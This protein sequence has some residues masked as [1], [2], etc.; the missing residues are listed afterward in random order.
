MLFDIHFQQ[1]YTEVGKLK[2]I[3]LHIPK[4]TKEENLFQ[5]LTWLQN[6]KEIRGA[7]YAD[8]RTVKFLL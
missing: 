4:N 5:N 3:H 1:R 7:W 6:F 8:N 2:N